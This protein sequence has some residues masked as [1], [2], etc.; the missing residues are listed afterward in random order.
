VISH[1]ISQSAAQ[2]CASVP[3]LG[4]DFLNVAEG[5]FCNMRTKTLYP[6]CD[7]ELGRIDNCFDAGMRKL[8]VGGI[9][10]RDVDYLKVIDWNHGS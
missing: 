4:P 2:L 7:E 10:K 5:L 9:H 3:S 6:V 1:D 8:V